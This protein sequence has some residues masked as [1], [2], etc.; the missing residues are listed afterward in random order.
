MWQNCEDFLGRKTFVASPLQR[1]GRG[2][3]RVAEQTIAAITWRTRVLHVW[4][5][6]LKLIFT[7]DNDEA[8]ILKVSL[9]HSSINQNSIFKEHNEEFTL[10]LWTNHLQYRLFF[11]FVCLLTIP[12]HHTNSSQYYSY[13]NIKIKERQSSVSIGVN[14]FSVILCYWAPLWWVQ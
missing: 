6:T 13:V 7:Q 9:E 14:P 2:G 5:L 10:K 8:Q 11:T 1:Q 12:I 4:K 3:G